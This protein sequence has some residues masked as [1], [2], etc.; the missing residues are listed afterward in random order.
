MTASDPERLKTLDDAVYSS[1]AL[2]NDWPDGQEDLVDEQ[3]KNRQN[4]HI[5][6]SNAP[7][8]TCGS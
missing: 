3:A 8:R 6:E 7:S 2:G 5:K 4:Q 1:L